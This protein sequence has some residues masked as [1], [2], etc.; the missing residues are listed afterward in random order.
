MAAI[1]FPST[2]FWVF[3]FSAGWA[4]FGLGLPPE[5]NSSSFEVEE[6]FFGLAKYESFMDSS[7]YSREINI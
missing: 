3:D 7:S 1:T 4:S 5:K 6:V 2:S